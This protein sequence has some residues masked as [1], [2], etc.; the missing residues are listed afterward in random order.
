MS[1]ARNRKLVAL[2]VLVVA[3]AGAGAYALHRYPTDVPV[4]YDDPLTHF[5]YGSIG[6]DTDN[7]LPKR[8]MEVLPEL[9]ADLLPPGSPPDWTAFGFLVEPGQWVPIGFSERTMRVPLL[10]MNCGLCHVGALRSAPDAPPTLILG[11]GNPNL[12]LGAFFA[13]LFKVVADPRYTP[14][15]LL[16][17]MEKKAPLDFLDRF[18]Y[19]RVVTQ[20]K[21][22]LQARQKLLGQLFDP[23]RPAMG[24]GRIDTFNPYKLSTLGAHYPDGLTPEEAIGTSRYP[25]IW[26]QEKKRGRALNWDGNAPRIED[27][28]AGAA[29]GA[30]ATYDSIDMAAVARVHSW[31]EKLQPPR[32]P[33]PVAEP[34]TLSQGLGVFL[35]HCARCHADN[36]AD[37]GQVVPIDAIGTDRSRF[38]SYTPKLNQLF[39]DMGNGR[40]WDLT[41]M[42]KT[43]GYL[44]RSLEGLW[45]RAPYLHNGSVPTVADLLSPPDQRPVTFQVG[46]G[47]VDHE[48]LGQRADVAEVAGRSTERFDTRLPGNG[49]GGH[50]YG[51]DLSAEDKVALIAYLKTL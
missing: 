1:S 3:A 27:R 6:G 43:D 4:T 11:L 24:H 15:G 31:L 42:R 23:A 7:G 37:I 44:N 38:A 50:T 46:H 14:D 2:G 13:F 40:P 19:R 30:G 35:Q 45:A 18:V 48:R 26:A 17:A 36:G 22:G 5:K 49:N 28:N 8:I 21:D 10:G 29:F 12:D 39:L 25:S 9:F 20:F 34:A 47:V 33:D 16:A 51:I 41:S 32:N